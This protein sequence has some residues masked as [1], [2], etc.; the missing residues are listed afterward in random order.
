MYRPI[1]EPTA[2]GQ[3]STWL[4]TEHDDHKPSKKININFKKVVPEAKIPTRATANSA[5]FDLYALESVTVVGGKGN[6]IV[7]TGI[8]IKLLP[9]TYGRIAM[10]SG[11]SINQHLA[12]SAGVIDRDFLAELK[13][14]VFCTH[15]E[16]SYTIKAGE[17]FAQ[18]IL[19]KLQKPH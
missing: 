10:R 4:E 19:L 1:I 5:G 7:R 14:I 6:F 9:K 2:G 16:H 18:I 12:V 17:R 8:C 11:L 3:V 13:V 15:T